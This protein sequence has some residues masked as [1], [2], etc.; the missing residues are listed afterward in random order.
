MIEELYFLQLRVYQDSMHFIYWHVS[1]LDTG[2]CLITTSG[3]L[4]SSSLELK[5][6]TI[7][8]NI[9]NFNSKRYEKNWSN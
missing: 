8:S 4:L 9:N 1:V 3:H 2:G 7:L 6:G 5:E